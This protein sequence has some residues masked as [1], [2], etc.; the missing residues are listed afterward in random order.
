M[1]LAVVYTMKL[2]APMHQLPVPQDLW[3]ARRQK[4]AE[5]SKD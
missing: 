4:D 2:R 3:D 5:N 1:M